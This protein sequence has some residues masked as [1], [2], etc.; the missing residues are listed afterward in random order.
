MVFA[1]TAIAPNSL[2]RG[3]WSECSP[4]AHAERAG[5]GY[6]HIV[7]G[8]TGGERTATAE[9]LATLHAAFSGIYMAN[10]GYDREMAMQ[11][12]EQGDA[13]LVCMGRPFISNPDLVERLE[14]DAPLN[15][16]DPDTLYG[17]GEEGYIDY[18][19]LRD[20]AA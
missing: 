16:L 8:E 15:E 4:I 6:V 18:P 9:Q 20:S 3:H 1:S 2:S 13:D 14:R 17:G 12:V 5:I 7:E 11:A 19:F 10:N